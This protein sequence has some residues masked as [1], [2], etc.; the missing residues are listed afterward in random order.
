MSSDPAAAMIRPFEPGA[1]F[2]R[3]VRLLA[4]VEAVDQSGEDVGEDRV[5]DLMRAPGHDPAH[6]RW[7]AVSPGDPDSLVGYGALW[8]SPASESAETDGAVHP[9]WRRR[10]LG[11]QLLARALARAGE[12]GACAVGAY[13]GAGNPAA[14]AFLRTHGF[15]RIAANTLL[16]AQADHPFPAPM[17]PAGYQ[18]RTYAEVADL[19]V[20]VEAFNRSHEGLWGHHPVTAEMVAGWLPEMPADGIFLAIAPGGQVAGICRGELDQRLSAR[21]GAATAYIDAPGV[22][23]EHREADLRR[24]LLLTA[25]AWLVPQGPAAIELES[26]GDAP[27]TL[28]EYEALGFAVARQALAFRVDL[29]EAPR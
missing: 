24:P 28:A 27:E 2:P 9:D 21:R 16:R 14:Q 18:P 12:L 5:R 11:G 29:L 10:G 26:W 22:V 3:L 13:A 25:I 19:A 23:P 4:A 1:D 17:W 20:L 8:K 15:A 6:D 7:A